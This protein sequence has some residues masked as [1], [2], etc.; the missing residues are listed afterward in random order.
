MH[1]VDPYALLGVPPGAGEREL[2][3]AYR[4][5]AKQWHPDRAGDEAA[6]RMAEINQAYE[7]ARLERRGGPP[8]GP[9]GGARPRGGPPRGARPA[10]PRASAG[11]MAA[12]AGAPRAGPRAARRA[13]RGRARPT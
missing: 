5:L 8:G 1:A 13:A 9:A 4:R 7:L 3:R 11:V 6:R 12:R 10:A 2:A